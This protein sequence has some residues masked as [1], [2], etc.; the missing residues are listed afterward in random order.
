MATKDEQRLAYEAGR[1]VLS[2]PPERQS[3]DACPFPEGTP[4]RAEWLR[5]FSEALDEAPPVDDLKKQLRAARKAA[6]A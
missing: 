6:E 3:I 1:A 5:G 4:E 2:E